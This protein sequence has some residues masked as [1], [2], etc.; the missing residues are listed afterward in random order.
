MK[1]FVWKDLSLQPLSE[2]WREKRKANETEKQ[3]NKPDEDTI[4]KEPTIRQLETRTNLVQRLLLG[5]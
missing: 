2:K 1:N 5:S 3:K 4:G